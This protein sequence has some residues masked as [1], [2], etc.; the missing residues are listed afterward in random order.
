M[1]PLFE[2][3]VAVDFVHRLDKSGSTR[4]LVLLDSPDTAEPARTTGGHMLIPKSA[5]TV[6]EFCSGQ[7]TLLEHY[8]AI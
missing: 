4:L 7:K 2:P 8:E 6:R 3:H 5:P 1:C